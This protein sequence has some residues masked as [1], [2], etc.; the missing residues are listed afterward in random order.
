MTQ[1]LLMIVAAAGIGFLVRGPTGAVP[2]LLVGA[3]VMAY[4]LRARALWIL[5]AALLA[6]DIF[7]GI[8]MRTLRASRP[9]TAASAP[10]R[11]PSR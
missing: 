7:V 10:V 2:S 5:V 1:L 11:H 3:A 8:A 4:R 9:Q 6:G